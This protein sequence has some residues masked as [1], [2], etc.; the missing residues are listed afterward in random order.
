MPMQKMY[1]DTSVMSTT[2]ILIRP[3]PINLYKTSFNQFVSLVT[4]SFLET[5]LEKMLLAFW[6]EPQLSAC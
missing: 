5:L 3:T 2:E 6:K 4:W 1:I